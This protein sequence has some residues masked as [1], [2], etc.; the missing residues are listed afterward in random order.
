MAVL[1][2]REIRS[3][4]AGSGRL[5]IAELA[6]EALLVRVLHVH[7]DAL[8]GRVAERL[9]WEDTEGLLDLDAE[10]LDAEEEDGEDGRR[11]D[12]RPMVPGP[13]RR[14]IRETTYRCLQSL[15]ILYKYS[16]YNV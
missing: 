7:N 16:A 12:G 6:E 9:E 8:D 1:L 11:R 4:R 2:A 5:A 14:K 3:C 10:L 15:I 13:S